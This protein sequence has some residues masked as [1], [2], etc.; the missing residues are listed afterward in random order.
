MDD[1][2][3]STKIISN[4]SKKGE[5]KV[6]EIKFKLLLFT[7]AELKIEFVKGANNKM[8]NASKKEGKTVSTKTKRILTFDKFD[9]FIRLQIGFIKFF[10]KDI[11]LNISEFLIIFFS[12]YYI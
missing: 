9:S 4:K 11:I 2:A 12:I 8:N 10:I 5:L 3:K 1:F 6:C 7:S